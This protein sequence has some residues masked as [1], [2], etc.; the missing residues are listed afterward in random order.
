[1]KI[2]LD[3]SSV[4]VEHCLQSNPPIQAQEYSED[5]INVRHVC[6]LSQS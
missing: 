6:G 5:G 4:L 1:M 2:N 3:D